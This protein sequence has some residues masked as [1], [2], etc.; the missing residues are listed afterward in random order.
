M[1]VEV[2]GA[3]EDVVL[4]HGALS[5]GRDT[6]A[7]QLHLADHAR[8]HVVDRRGYVA[9]GP[10]VEGEVGWPVD[11]PDLVALLED[12]GGAHVVGHSYGGVDALMVAGERPELVRSLVVVEPPVYDLADD[13]EVSALAARIGEVFERGP[14]LSPDEFYAQWAALVLGLHDRVVQYAVHHWTPEH[15]A[16]ADATRFEALPTAEP[17]RWDGVRAVA[18]RVVVSGGWP[19]EHRRAATRPEGALGARAF[20]RAAEGVAARA[21]V[22]VVRFDGSGHTPQLTEPEAFDDLLL[23]TWAAAG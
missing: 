3:G 9:A 23:R 15:R 4:V 18:Q 5:W 17:V 11:V 21:G 16:A 6:F 14:G 13:A 2:L 8:L 1:A 10:P 19:T 22:D 7:A 20:Q 12:L